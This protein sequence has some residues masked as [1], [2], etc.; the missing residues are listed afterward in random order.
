MILLLDT[1]VIMD[2]ILHREG[3]ENAVSIL[4][5]AYK[6]EAIEC[7][8]ASSITDINYIA[9]KETKDS[10]GAQESIRKMLEL[11]TVLPVSRSDIEAA[12]N[13]E[14]NDFEDAVQYA[15]ARANGVDIIVSRN[16]KDFERTE[17][18]VMTPQAFLEQLRLNKLVA[19][20]KGNEPPL[21]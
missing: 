4:E 14:W 17:I 18:P 8:T 5:L 2:W 3:Y 16:R 7:V 6:E 9:Y 10:L 13:L 11:I 12:L 1:N 19:Y 20:R 21:E 15:V